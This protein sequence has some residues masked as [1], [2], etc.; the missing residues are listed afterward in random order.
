MGI[1]AIRAEG[2][3][4]GRARVP[5]EPLLQDLQLPALPEALPDAQ[6][7]EGGMSA[8]DSASVAE[9]DLPTSVKALLGPM[10]ALTT[11]LRAQLISA[12]KS[13]D[14]DPTD[15]PFNN[16]AEFDQFLKS[17]IDQARMCSHILSHQHWIFVG[18]LLAACLAWLTSPINAMSATRGG[19]AGVEDCACL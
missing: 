13:K 11:P 6:L 7:L 15:I 4:R 1:G 9:A 12:L 3:R 18:S 5:L 16:A 8:P 19:V 14:F 10:L 17:R 2:E